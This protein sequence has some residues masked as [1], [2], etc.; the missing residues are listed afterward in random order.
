MRYKSIFTDNK[1]DGR[2]VQA[3]I[4]DEEA[5]LIALKSVGIINTIHQKAIYLKLR[6]WEPTGPKLYDHYD[7]GGFFFGWKRDGNIDPFAATGRPFRDTFEDLRDCG[8]THRSEALGSETFGSEQDFDLSVPDVDETTDSA[9]PSRNA[10]VFM[11][12]PFLRR[13]SDDRDITVLMTN[14]LQRFGD[15]KSYHSK[16]IRGNTALHIACMEGFSQFVV[17]QIQKGANREERNDLGFTPLHCA[18]ESGHLNIVTWLVE[19]GS[20][21]DAL[22]NDYNTPLILAHKNGMTTVVSFLQ[23]KYMKVRIRFPMFRF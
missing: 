14:L 15:K 19:N 2:V 17:L 16:D 6:F 3:L 11:G 22:D 10:D 12:A 1:I 23:Q 21:V 7:N 18:C 13:I 4:D 20:N 9:Y 8:D 5:L